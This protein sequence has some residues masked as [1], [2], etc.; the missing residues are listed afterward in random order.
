MNGFSKV[1]SRFK[2]SSSSA[3][4]NTLIKERDCEYCS[5]VASSIPPYRKWAVR[6]EDILH[7]ASHNC[8]PHFYMGFCII[9][10]KAMAIK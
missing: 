6:V 7:T 4:S 10:N 9:T 5:T 3:N 8:Q 2:A 1:A